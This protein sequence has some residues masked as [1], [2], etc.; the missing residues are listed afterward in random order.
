MKIY[1]MMD[2]MI[3]ICIMNVKSFLYK[4]GQTSKT[5]TLELATILHES[6]ITCHGHLTV[7]KQAC[8]PKKLDQH[9]DKL[10]ETTINTRL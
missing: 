3:L 6:L 5:L 7:E 8:K 1:S 10:W 4:H 2:L 9:A